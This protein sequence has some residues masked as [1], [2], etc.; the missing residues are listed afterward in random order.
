MQDGVGNNLPLQVSTTGV[1]FT[2][3]VTGI[4]ASG[5]TSIIAGTGITVDAATGDVTVTATGGG[6][7]VTYDLDTIQAIGQIELNLNGSDASQSTL[8]I[9]EGTNITL[10]D[11][12]NAGFTISAAGGG[13]SPTIITPYRTFNATG[14]NI[15]NFTMPQNG[16]NYN[17]GGLQTFIDL[18][19]NRRFFSEIWADTVSKVAVLVDPGQFDGTLVAEIFDVHPTTGMP[20]DVIA[21]SS[22]STTTG[23]GG[24]NWYTMDF[25][26]VTLGYDHYYMSVRAN[27]GTIFGNGV[28]GSVNASTQI[29]RMVEFDI[30]NS[31]PD[32]NSFGDYI[33]GIFDSSN[34]TG[35]YALN[36][37]FAYRTDM[38]PN[39]LYKS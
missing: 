7:G 34:S 29:G 12:G 28:Y 36:Y 4:P 24:L 37:N 27:A 16:N 38:Y 23:T 2:G 15:W 10:T 39:F 35:N 1:N 5:V 18:Q 22:T 3:T 33:G 19:L 9:S 20:K 6:G 21:T 31:P 32:P 8:V 26:G 17:P 30:N 25:T 14:D 11:D 13:G